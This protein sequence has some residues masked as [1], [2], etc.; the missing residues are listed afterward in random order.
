[1]P[2]IDGKARIK[3]PPGT[4]SGKIFRLKGK[5]FPGVNS[6]EKGDQ[7]IYVN[8]WTPQQVSPEEKAMLDKMNASPNFKPQP[9]KSD[10]SF[11]DK[12]RE[13]FS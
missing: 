3:I 11:F 7:L 5:G 10:K 8:V 13:M 6:Y 12:V 4:Q 9:E 1:V 2:T